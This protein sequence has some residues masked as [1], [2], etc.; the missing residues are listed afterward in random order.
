MVYATRMTKRDETV[1]AKL[2]SFG[3]SKKEV[4]I[5]RAILELGRGTVSQ[6][7]R[8]ANVTR[9]NAYN[10]LDSLE[11][12]GIVRISGKEPKQE[13]VVESPDSLVVMLEKRL[14]DAQSSLEK[15]REFVPELKSMQMVEDR[16]EIKFYEGIEGLKQI[17]EDTLTATEEIRA[18]GSYDNVSEIV[19]NYFP[20]YY[21]KRIAK[22][23][24]V[25]GIAPQTPVSIEAKN[26]GIKELRKLAL[27]S[28]DKYLF[29]PQTEID[30][31]DDKIMIAS[32][33]EKLGIIIKSQVIVGAMGNI[34]ELAWERAVQIDT[35]TVA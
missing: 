14:Q 32:W 11:S 12:K 3:L 33:Q 5:Y 8:K 2:L 35:D 22:G 1:T 25:R 24:S 31:Y 13:Y 21:Q 26:R 20:D 16:P 9:T 29:A 17:Y 23:I 27:I 7:S 10:I 15:A 4:E 18:Y 30:I 19:R 34:F 28:P 6:I